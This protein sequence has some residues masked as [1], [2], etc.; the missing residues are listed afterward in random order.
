M[1]AEPAP[2]GQVG[3]GAHPGLVVLDDQRDGADLRLL[4]RRPGVL[5]ARHQGDEDTAGAEHAHGAGGRL[6]AEGVEDDV[7]ALAGFSEVLGAVVD[8]GV[9]AELAQEGMLG[10]RSPYR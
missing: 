3:D 8:A 2:V 6:P 10:G 7:V 9:R 1:G 4:G 5:G